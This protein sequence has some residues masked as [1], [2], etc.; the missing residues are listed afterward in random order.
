MKQNTKY[1]Q[2][3]AL[4]KMSSRVG[5]IKLNVQLGSLLIKN[6]VHDNFSVQLYLMITFEW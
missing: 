1:L 6:T 3:S 5:I 2:T 4:I